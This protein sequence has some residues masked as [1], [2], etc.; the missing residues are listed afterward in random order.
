MKYKLALICFGISIWVSAQNRNTSITDNVDAELGALITDRPDA[1]ES[2]T[3][4]PKG[5][6]QVETGGFY[7]SFEENAVKSEN[8][9]FVIDFYYVYLMD[10]YVSKHKYLISG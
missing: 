1:T 3:A 2:P 9:T 5:F 6:L 4:M 8:Y 10:S 7:E